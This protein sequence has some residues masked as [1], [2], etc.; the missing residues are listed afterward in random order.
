MENDGNE[1][2]T[3]E[4]INLEELSQ[5]AIDSIEN[6]IDHN[7]A[8]ADL[9]F[10]EEINQLHSP[11]EES[12]VIEE[13]KEEKKP[14]VFKRLKD[15]WSKLPRKN[16]II[17]IVVI[18]I[19]LILI[20]IGV[21]MLT[22]KKPTVEP[23]IPDVILE[24]DNYRYENGVLHFLEDDEEI[25]TYECTNKDETKCF[26][27][28][29]TNDDEFDG[30]KQVNEDGDSIE[31]RSKIYNERFVFVFDNKNENDE[32]IK[33]YD[34]KNNEVKE[35]FLQVK[36]YDFI[37]DVVILKNM[38]SKYGLVT[39]DFDDVTTTIPYE[40]DKLGIL[41]DDEDLE[42]VIAKKDGSYYVIN[43]NNELLS[44]AMA[45]AIVDANKDH[46]KIKDALGNYQV[47]DYHG[48]EIGSGDYATLLNDYVI[49]VRDLQLFVTDYEKHPMNLDGIAIKND[50]YNPIAYYKNNKLTKTEK[51]FDA[52]VYDKNLIITIYGNDTDDLETTTLNLQDGIFSKGLAF[53]NYLNGKL[54][55]YAD[56]AKEQLLGSY[57]CNNRN[58]VEASNSSLNNC[59]L[60]PESMLVE[61]RANEKEKDVSS[62]LGLL[63]IFFNRYVFIKDGESIVLY[64]LQAPSD[65]SIKAY[66]TKVDAKIYSKADKVTFV[67]DGTIYYIAESE[68]SGNYGLAKITK[69]GV[70]GKISFDY[71]NLKRLGDYYVAEADNGYY[72]VDAGGKKLSWAK[73]GEILDYNG[74]YLKFLKDNDY[75]VSAFNKDSDQN[76]YDYIELYDKYYA[77]VKENEDDKKYY[78]SVF[79][80][81][82]EEPVNSKLS[83][84]EL[85]N[86][87][88]EGEGIKAF[89]LTFTN[90]SVKVEI[91]DAK[92]KEYTTNNYSL[93][94]DIKQP[95]KP[96]EPVKEEEETDKEEENQDEQTDNNNDDN[97]NNESAL[98]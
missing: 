83:N 38:D 47:F 17:I 32:I 64:D 59:N 57:S 51:A 36:A 65:S 31:L 43:K 33:L 46:L 66:Y 34:M 52:E 94:P 45:E 88:F 26:V 70:E 5:S 35:E 25:G 58:T 97:N 19:L 95:T 73:E 23:D 75:Y 96:K 29:L 48:K 49:F 93:T 2:Q 62:S 4:V 76:K 78:L 13:P 84:I 11:S 77:A 3:K 85:K 98:E 72:L 90:N 18:I 60:A 61:T 86:T 82:S 20:G 63:P 54:Y 81:G 30:L 92:E 79:A 24:E 53:I 1:S 37:D 56:E 68:R 80:Y 7:M 9:Q 44:N 74:Q 6:E 89:N 42:R 69:D 50:H 12:V 55:F 41:N 28:Y 39:F 40:Y 87:K 8:E 16:K 15:K 91:G 21:F 67:N 27:A 10:Q 14:N 22:R 71:K